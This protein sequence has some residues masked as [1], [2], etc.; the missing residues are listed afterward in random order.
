VVFQLLS[1]LSVVCRL[2]G[3]LVDRA[4][5]ADTDTRALAAFVV[6]VGLDGDIGTWAILCGIGETKA[7]VAR[8]FEKL[9]F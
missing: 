8:E 9:T 6:E 7:E 5:D 2:L 1:Y 3:P 4:I